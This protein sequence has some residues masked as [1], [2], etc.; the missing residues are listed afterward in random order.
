MPLQQA[1]GRV[2]AEPIRSPAPVP[3]QATALRDGWAV[4]ASDVV[5][6]TSYAPVPLAAPPTWVE[7]GEPMPAG[8][9]AVLPPDA[10]IDSRGHAEIVADA[11]P[12]ENVRR[13][14]ADAARG[15]ILR[16][17]G[18]RVRPSDIAVAC[19]AGVNQVLVREARA[20]ILS[21]PGPAAL[22]ITADFVARVAEAAGAA[23][24]QVGLQ[25]RDVDT[26]AGAAMEAASDL[27]LIVGGTGLGRH[28]HAAA[29]LA[30]CGS[31]ITHG[32]ALRPG[33]TSGCG[34]L[35]TTPAI[36]VP[37]RIEAAL[38]A[39]LM[40]VL[41]CLDHLMGATPRQPSLS[42]PLT[43]KVSSAVG[44]T[45]IVLLRGTGAGLEPLAAGDLTLAAIGT[46]DGWLAVPPESEGF[47]AGETIRAF[48]L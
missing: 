30:A 27:V 47:A 18:E 11:A 22:E 34:V 15:V 41:P 3:A 9:D 14:G 16:A 38:A 7:T 44:L 48:L 39:T 1:E 36:L 28:D 37:G 12:G 42:G 20:R 6:A 23:V 31:L 24:E 21:L 35:G 45:E 33:E 46:A 29:A 26:I 32:I 8:T 2:L 19:A 25:S 17:A 43:R 40:L 5:G 13:A 10:V 4:A